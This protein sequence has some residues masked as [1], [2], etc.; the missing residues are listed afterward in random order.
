MRRIAVS[1]KKTPER[2]VSWRGASTLF[3]VLA[4]LSTLLSPV[5]STTQVVAA[6]TEDVEVGQ[7]DGG[8]HPIDALRLLDTSTGL[9]NG[10]V[11]GPLAPGSTRSVTVQGHGS[12]PTEGVS[13][14][15]LQ[16]IGSAGRPGAVTVGNQ[17]VQLNARA[18][19]HTV[20]ANVSQGGV[21]LL[22]NSSAP[23]SLSVDVV[24]WIPTNGGYSPLPPAEPAA[25]VV[26]AR[27]LAQVSV[28]DLAEV[29]TQ[30]VAAVALSIA[31]PS[32]P[33]R[34]HLSA[35]TTGEPQPSTS[36]V[37]LNPF[38]SNSGIALVRPSTSGSVS[39]SNSSPRPISV[40]VGT[41]G[42]FNEGGGYTAVTPT[43]VFADSIRGSVRNWTR[44]HSVVKVQVAGHAGVPQAGVGAV[45]VAI[46][47][48][49]ST[50]PGLLRV[51]GG[52]ASPAALVFSP[53]R[54]STNTVVIRPEPGGQIE[55]QNDSFGFTNLKI[56]VVGWMPPGLNEVDLANVVL[57]DPATARFVS[58]NPA[59]VSTLEAPSGSAIVPG[60]IIVISP[61]PA[62]LQ[63]LI[64]VVSSVANVAGD[65]IVT[66]TPGSIAD[67][68]PVFDVAVDTSDGTIVEA[69][70]DQPALLRAVPLQAA[71]AASNKAVSWSC[72][73]SVTAG[74]NASLDVS[75]GS[76][77]LR[78][79]GRTASSVWIEMTIN[80]HVG[81]QFSASASAAGQCSGSASIFSI[82]LPTIRTCVPVPFACI[83]LWFDQSIKGSA[84]A[85]L[86]VEGS[87]S[88]AANWDANAQL[89]YRFG[90]SAG[91]V[92]NYSITSGAKPSL[93]ASITGDIW[94]KG[95][96]EI[97]AYGTLGLGVG[98]G[99]A[100]HL[101]G[102]TSSY[103][104]RLS[105]ALRGEWYAF[106]NLRV[107]RFETTRY[108]AQY[109]A[110]GWTLWTLPGPPRVSAPRFSLSGRVPT[111]EIRVVAPDGGIAF[112]N[113]G[114]PSTGSTAGYSWNCENGTT[115]SR[116]YVLLP[117]NTATRLSGNE[118]DGVYR[119]SGL[120]NTPN[121][122]VFDPWKPIGAD[123]Y[124]HCEPTGL[125]VVSKNGGSI[126]GTGSSRTWDVNQL[127]AA[128][129]YFPFQL[130]R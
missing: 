47:A 20:L 44:P 17:I 114:F 31:V 38:Q 59:G 28:A 60:N 13:A 85:D 16:L 26:P 3:V 50:S 11:P 106:A 97:A 43:T 6:D 4:A 51:G 62:R 127:K 87:A 129:L 94:V 74:V 63:G 116:G 112:F 98:L 108:S 23:V 124:G 5:L 12:I 64:G 125:V 39:F 101:D 56:D 105:A 18:S 69:P 45:V 93:D 55:V 67:V 84:T 103:W 9:G 100:L 21:V 88:V 86:K 7:P 33:A 109:P 122:R 70:S 130:P 91:P 40:Q 71:A 81:A 2:R 73:G 117:F 95:N 25:V 49:R 48:E 37:D 35:W 111:L 52:Q 75:P 36:T 65:R 78:G 118:Y 77:R 126:P 119:L 24:G 76:F 89:G 68:I 8:Y 72:R 42:W 58:Y 22:K 90:R 46:R 32:V 15:V 19:A 110:N 128:G 1:S 54:P 34:G 123:V 61:T 120:W 79:D 80:P 83:P 57:V 10:N 92:A 96:Y 30:S 82:P 115:D 107:K 99:P 29:P 121:Q 14:V 102:P 66:T 113:Q 53:G 104:L 27:G 41:I